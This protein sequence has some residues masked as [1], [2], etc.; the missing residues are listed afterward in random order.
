MEAASSLCSPP[1]FCSVS[2]RLSLLTQNLSEIIAA[3]ME[4][5]VRC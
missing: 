2:S 1:S 3:T 4:A 5:V